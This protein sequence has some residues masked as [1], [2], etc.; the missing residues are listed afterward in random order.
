M[1]NKTEALKLALEAFEADASNENFLVLK[2]CVREAL[3]DSALDRMVE[4]ARELGLDYEPAQKDYKAF[5][6]GKKWYSVEVEPP[7]KTGSQCTSKCQQ[8]EQPAQQQEPEPD[9]VKFERHWRKT[10]GDKKANRELPRHPLQPQT[11]IQDSANRHWVTWQ[12]AVMSVA[13]P[14]DRKPLTDEQ[15][16]YVVEMWRGG[17]WTAGDI[18]DAVEAAHG[19]K[20][21]A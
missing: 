8:C 19:I 20:G 4:N 7:C 17:N 14:A 1:T 16:Q 3:A 10:R 12:A 6:D 15:R 11:Y 2:H 13:P 5:Y 21:S 18:I 9:R